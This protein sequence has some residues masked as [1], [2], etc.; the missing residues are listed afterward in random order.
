MIC[1]IHSGLWVGG[2]KALNFM[3]KVPHGPLLDTTIDSW[4]DILLQLGVIRKFY[5][6]CNTVDGSEI[7]RENHLGC[8]KPGVNTGINHQPQ[9]VSW[10]RISSGS[11]M[12]TWFIPL[13]SGF[14]TSWFLAGCLKHQTGI[15]STSPQAQQVFT[16]HLL[17]GFSES[18]LSGW[19][20]L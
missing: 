14:S 16:Q 6:G 3:G 7:R 20:K 13:F 18:W 11:Y 5:G 9:L 17:K 19:A 10:T 12:Q 15:S 2:H 8:I 1:S 4:E